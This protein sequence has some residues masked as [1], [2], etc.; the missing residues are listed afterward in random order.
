MHERPTPCPSKLLLALQMRS[1]HII[2]LTLDNSN[3][4]SATSGSLP[5]GVKR[6]EKNTFPVGDV[7]TFGWKTRPPKDVE[8][9]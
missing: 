4:R 6:E 3:G 8:N 7:F 5:K 1:K 2:V 9:N